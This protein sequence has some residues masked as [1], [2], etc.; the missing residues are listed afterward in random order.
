MVG[1]HDID[2]KRA[3]DALRKKGYTNDEIRDLWSRATPHHFEDQT[4]IQFVDKRFIKSLRIEVLFQIL[5]M[6]FLR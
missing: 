1:D 2:Y 6:V 5:R 4:T 3:K